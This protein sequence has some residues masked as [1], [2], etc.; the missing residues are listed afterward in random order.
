M[1]SPHFFA[2]APGPGGSVVLREEEARHAI[3]SLRLRVGERFTS[4]D[5]RGAVA[6]CRIVRVGSDDLE[7][8]VE[9]RRVTAEPRPRLAVLL[10]APKGERL[11][12]AVQKLTELGADE[13]AIL[14]AAR[15]VRRPRGEQALRLAER[16]KAVANEA[17]KQSRRSFLPT[18]AGPLAWKD[19]I[20]KALPHGPVVVLWER[21]ARGLLEILPIETPARVALVVGPEGGIPDEDAH[22]AEGSGALLGS[23]GTNILRTETAAVAASAVV[24]S[25]YGRLG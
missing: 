13:I 20:S 14:E 24:L 16:L 9:D 15:S 6:R 7:G 25:R 4:S 18:L 2:G 1:S 19:G 10:A 11:T 12:W 8:E 21:A 23:L 22:R 3:R 5:G 17:A